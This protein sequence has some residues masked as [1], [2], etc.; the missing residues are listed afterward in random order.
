MPIGSA[1]S[2]IL[3]QKLGF[4]GMYILALSM[5]SVTL[6]YGIIFIKEVKTEISS[7][8]ESKEPPKAPSCLNFL[9]DFFSLD[10]IKEAIQVTF[11]EGKNKRKMKI[12]SLMIVVIV[13]S[14]PL[15]G[16]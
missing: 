3:F 4:Y 8:V 16:S 13:V 10:S 7:V 2:G 15:L 11:K 5:Y 14:G 1:V 9:E 6:L 12:I